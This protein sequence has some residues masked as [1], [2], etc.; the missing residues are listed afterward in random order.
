[1]SNHAILTAETHRDLRIAT[2]RSAAFGDDVMCCIT[3]PAE[4][5][6][7]QNEYPIVF[8]MNPERDGFSAFAL[9]GF[10]NGENLFLNGD[11]WEAR[12]RPLAIDIQPFLI[13]MP[14]GGPSQGQGGKQVHIDMASSRIAKAEGT[15]VF[16][17]QGRPTPYLETIAEKLGELDAG[18]QVAGDFFTALMAYKLLEPLALDITLNDGSAHRFVGFHV[19]H[20]ERL[21]ALDAEAVADLHGKDYLMPI[22]MALAS[23]SNIGSLVDRK[24]GRLL[25]V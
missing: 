8:R 18:Y 19:I 14:A 1:M 11:R 24:N 22:Y 25:N 5:R 7:V 17:E 6:Q 20:E 10:E 2:H 21:R 9:F 3:V 12:Y 16:D 4:F 23:L 13:G 15:R